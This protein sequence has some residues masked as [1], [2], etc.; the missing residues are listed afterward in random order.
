[1]IAV[2]ELMSLASNDDAI[3]DKA[4]LKVNTIVNLYM[5]LLQ[6]LLLSYS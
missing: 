3:D 2:I 4:K 1:M 6:V 5:L